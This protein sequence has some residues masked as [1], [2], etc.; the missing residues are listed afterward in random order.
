MTTVF[1][2]F[3]LNFVVLFLIYVIFV[4]GLNIQWGQA[5]ILNFGLVAFAMLG[6]YITGILMFHPTASSIM[7]VGL[8]LPFLVAFPIAVAVTGV[9]AWFI[10]PIV[11]FGLEELAIIT[12]AFAVLVHI[13][14]DNEAWL[15]GGTTGLMITSNLNDRLDVLTYNL[16][17]VGILLVVALA[18]YYFT[19]TLNFS[20][21]GRILN[22]IRLDELK[23]KSLGIDAVSYRM[24]AFV[25][26]SVIVA[27]GGSLYLYFVV[28]TV[29]DLFP[30]DLTFILWI[31]LLLG[32]SGNN[33]GAVLGMGIYMLLDMLARLY[34][35]IPAHPEVGAG[36]KYVVTGLLLVVVIVRRPE[37]IL[38]PRR[39]KYG[40]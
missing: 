31:A 10:S 6:A 36:L 16:A 3:L 23:A 25:I 19:R 8:G 32:G 1:I 24:K 26:G 17:F 37:G 12:L 40:G 39:S 18:V 38:G 35:N 4:L 9:I 30:V 34:L 2:A 27:I 29:P 14:T 11:K 5:G 13:V 20:Q 33:R 7:Q 21:F 28:R 22:A 15:T